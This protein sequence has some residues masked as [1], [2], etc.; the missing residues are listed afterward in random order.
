MK[1]SV[2][3]LLLCM[4]LKSLA[5]MSEDKKG[6]IGITTGLAFPSKDLTYETDSGTGL[7]VN[8]L[9]FGYPVWKNIGFCASLLGGAHLSKTLREDALSV[10]GALL[11]GPMF[12]ANLSQKSML[13]LRTMVGSA[14]SM[15]DYANIS[16]RSAREGWS[17]GYSVGFLY[18]FNH[19]K[20]WCF[21][22][23]AD[24]FSAKSSVYNYLGEI[25]AINV[26]AGIGFRLK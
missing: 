3:I 5:Q 4:A 15:F 10:Y 17:Y 21:M 19:S 2:S 18:R 1:L 16:G 24:Y 22:F 14:F 13:H 6:Y 20:N 25:A 9:N 8:L 23:N 11:A 12:S 7:N 26:N